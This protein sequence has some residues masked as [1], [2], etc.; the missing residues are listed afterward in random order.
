MNKNYKI[1]QLIAIAAA[2]ALFAA[3]NLF[4]SALV[5]R[6]GIKIDLTS[7][8]RYDLTEEGMEYL[9]SYDSDT[10]IYILASVTE[11]DTNAR[12]VLDRCAAASPRIKIKNVDVEKNPTF[13]RA[14]VSDGETLTENSV[15]VVSGDKSRVIENSEFYPT[16]NGSVTGI[17]V[18]SKI[19]SA[20]KYVSSDAVYRAYFTSGHGEADFGGAKEALE[21]ENYI[22]GELDTLTSDIPADADVVIVPRPMRDFTGGETAKLDAY[23]RGGGA[24]QIYVGGECPRLENISSWLNAAGIEISESEI[25]ESRDN[26][27]SAGS[28]YLFILN[29]VKNDVTE[30]VIAKNKVSGYIPFAKPLKKTPVSG[31]YTIESRLASSDNSYTT[32]NFENPSR[33]TAEY[34]GASDIALMSVNSDTGGRI[35]VSGTT[36]LLSYGVSDIARL[37]FGN[38]DYFI[39]LTDSMSGA[40]ES[41]TVPPKSVGADLLVMTSA[42]RTV[43]FAIVVILVPLLLLGLGAAVFLKRRDM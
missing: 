39:A 30:G 29:Y 7:D 41:F 28:S 27:V 3:V 6:T 4:M 22:V 1:T 12:A 38:I 25:V 11:Q 9:K 10:T 14:Y 18:E 5:K 34:E 8:K 16:S 19:I 17:D 31:A 2:L 20:L 43:M 13:G 42:Q 21:A 26:A 36:M 24:V 15:I 35:Y 33:D 37:G 40:G 23:I 32:S